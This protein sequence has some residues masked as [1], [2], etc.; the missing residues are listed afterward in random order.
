MSTAGVRLLP[1]A[2]SGVAQ[3]TVDADG[4]NT[5]AVAPGANTL[6]DGSGVVCVTPHPG[7]TLVSLFQNE[8]PQDATETLIE[9]AHAAGHRVI[10]N[11]APTLSRRPSERILRIVDYL[12]CNR[13][14][15]AALTG[16]SPAEAEIDMVIEQTRI[17][18][19]WGVANLVVTLGKRGSLWLT[20]NA[21][22]AVPAFPVSAIDT[23]GAGD[24]FCGVFAAALSEGSDPRAAMR[25]AAAA[26]A[27]STTRQG[28]QTSMPAREEVDAFLRQRGA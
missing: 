9:K 25:A 13:N 27:I 26:A 19:A 5:I 14:E 20:A 4:E 28:A 18:L 2:R 22:V 21:C 1:G 3:I 15:L 6:F 7:E 16:G 10:W 17:P 24:C 8:I 11:L 23:V 12:V